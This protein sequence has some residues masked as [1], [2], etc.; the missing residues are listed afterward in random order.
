VGGQARAGETLISPRCPRIRLAVRGTTACPPRSRSPRSV[1]AAAWSV[2]PLITLAA[3]IS[4]LLSKTVAGATASATP[5][6][7]TAKPSQHHPDPRP[8]RTSPRG[9]CAS[10][11]D[12]SCCPGRSEEPG[13]PGRDHHQLVIPR[14]LLVVRRL[15]RGAHVAAARA[16]RSCSVTRSVSAATRARPRTG[17]TQSGRR[18]VPAPQACVPARHT[19]AAGHGWPP[20][21]G[22]P[23]PPAQIPLPR[24]LRVITV[25]GSQGRHHA[26]DRLAVKRSRCRRRRITSMRRRFLTLPEPRLTGEGRRLGRA[27]DRAR[28]PNRAERRGA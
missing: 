14:Q 4:V 18:G 13:A 11:D 22:Q 3:A 5:A 24:R 15:L 8:R 27:H 21:D 1:R 17:R 6:R 16:I 9:S 7:A 19:A 10:G 25:P 26:G 20:G 23:V 2:A 28:S 12:R